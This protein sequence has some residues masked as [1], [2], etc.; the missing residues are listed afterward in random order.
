MALYV[1]EC[2][3]HCILLVKQDSKGQSR[4]KA[5]VIRFH[6]L[7]KEIARTWQPSLTSQTDRTALLEKIYIPLQLE[8]DWSTNNPGAQT[9]LR[10]WLESLLSCIMSTLLSPSSGGS[11]VVPL[12]SPG[13]FLWLNPQSLAQYSITPANNRLCWLI[14]N[15]WG[16]CPAMCPHIATSIILIG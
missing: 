7:V 16:Q 11:G 9:T 13:G 3:F 2:H 10:K 4:F 6:L 8:A 1:P 15:H 5:R 12:S 14:H